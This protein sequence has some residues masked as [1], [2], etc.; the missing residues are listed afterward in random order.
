MKENV[1]TTTTCPSSD[2]AVQPSFGG[3]NFKVAAFQMGVR[4]KMLPGL[5]LETLS[6][7]Q[8]RSEARQR[9]RQLDDRMLADVG[10]SRADVEGEARK[11][12][13]TA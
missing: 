2:F 1:M 10:L 8:R 7:W 13:W 4:V 11:P 12:F 3:Q 5:V 9:L 6:R